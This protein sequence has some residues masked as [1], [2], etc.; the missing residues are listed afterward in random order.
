MF[1]KVLMSFRPADSSIVYSEFIFDREA[2]TLA[3]ARKGLMKTV[4][5]FYGIDVFFQI[6][7]EGEHL[8]DLYLK[9]DEWTW[10]PMG[11]RASP[12]PVNSDGHIA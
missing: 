11:I 4:E 8:G 1:F 7:N 5:T 10:A 9:D 2:D 6:S 12:C 3:D